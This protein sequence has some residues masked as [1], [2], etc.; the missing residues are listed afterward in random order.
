[1]EEAAQRVEPL[2]RL[3]PALRVVLGCQEPK[4]LR[5]AM[6]LR[7]SGGDRG[8]SGGGGKT[9]TKMARELADALDDIAAFLGADVAAVDDA[10]AVTA[11][12]VVDPML[13]HIVRPAGGV[14]GGIEATAKSRKIALRIVAWLLA[15]SPRGAG[16]ECAARVGAALGSRCT[17]STPKRARLAA[18]IALR[19]AAVTLVDGMPPSCSPDLIAPGLL[20]T[21]AE[22]EGDAPTRLQAEA[23]DCLLAITARLAVVDHR[24]LWRAVPHLKAVTDAVGGWWPVACAA[25]RLA[26]RE[27][28]RRIER[29]A[30]GGDA[31]AWSPALAGAWKDWAPLL[32]VQ[33]GLDGIVGAAGDGDGGGDGGEDDENVGAVR[34]SRWLNTAAVAASSEDRTASETLT[35]ALISTG[36]LVGQLGLAAGDGG[37]DGEARRALRAAAAASLPPALGSK[38]AV[39]QELAA[40]IVR[41]ALVSEHGGWG[42]EQAALLEGLLPM[43]EDAT[44][45]PAAPGLASLAAALVAA[46]PCDSTR[47]GA[48]PGLARVLRACG[49]DAEDA[50]RSALAVLREVLAITGA[51]TRA[52]E[53]T[54]ATDALLEALRDPALAVRK[55]AAAAFSAL[56]IGD[57]LPPLLRALTA[58]DDREWSAAGE[59]AVHAMRAWTETM[60]ARAALD[61]F[62]ASVHSPVGLTSEVDAGDKHAGDIRVTNAVTDDPANESR[63]VSILGRWSETLT[64]GQAVEVAAGVAASALRNPGVAVIIKAASALASRTGEP[65]A[66]RETFAAARAAM[67]SQPA[68]S[69]TSANTHEVFGRLAPLLLLR[70]LPLEAWDDDHLLCDEVP[71]VPDLL[72]DRALS[73]GRGGEHDEVRRVAAEL[74]GRAHPD[75]AADTRATRLAA[76]LEADELAAARACMFSLC[77]S[78]AF[79]GVDACPAHSPD[80][81]PVSTRACV[82]GVLGDRV[83]GENDVET[84]K[85]QM[86]A[87]ETLAALIRAEL[88]D[89]SSP[90]DSP[91]EPRRRDGGLLEPTETGDSMAKSFAKIYVDPLA[92][93]ETRSVEREPLITELDGDDDDETVPSSKSRA[94]RP[95]RSATLDGI[96]AALAGTDAPAWTSPKDP[97]AST[98]ARLALA[99]V[100]VSVAR[101]PPGDAEAAAAYANK[102]LPALARIAVAKTTA[103]DATR[104][105]AFQCAMVSIAT[106]SL[107]TADVSTEEVVKATG[108]AGAIHASRL[109][110]AASAALSDDGLDDGVRMAAA[111]LV[112]ALIAGDDAMLEALAESVPEVRSAL[113]RAVDTAGSEEL[114][115][116]CRQLLHCMGAVA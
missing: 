89:D 57:V 81:S 58:K 113:R 29:V 91:D 40:S 101:R 61:A 32:A 22:N 107:N 45:G 94:S 90:D 46:E 1:M 96:L 75:A 62:I 25:P 24:A 93:R 10:R 33:G 28:S 44:G 8:A 15:P 20:A 47:A 103:D 9:A 71:S 68:A 106:T 11:Y 14:A 2:K 67:A 52:S 49:H 66:C 116:T 39:A 63:A 4:A 37:G 38:S 12:P 82:T 16:D 83:V 95:R 13:E 48:R 99:N 86:G 102:A 76:A 97:N 105:A 114:A 108:S 79:R 88:E 98:Q 7:A 3:G 23:A 112:T 111:R 65:P 55:S 72:L 109:A 100:L 53:V 27:A 51:D 60:G 18:C 92:T 41:A 73:K 69:N 30:T 87:M 110:F 43:L 64:E 6:D 34:L 31:E 54:V 19:H 84:Q 115:G 42:P 80:A 59:S 70:T 36:L 56:R 77:S 5:R 74:H 85:T 50:R 78:L 35:H 21:V 17:P 104:A 26:A